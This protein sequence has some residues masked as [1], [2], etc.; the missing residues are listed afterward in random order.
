LAL[1]EFK[2]VVIGDWVAWFS[3]VE[4]AALVLGG[5]G[6]FLDHLG[7]LLNHDTLARMASILLLISVHATSSL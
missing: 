3:L 4:R 2:H 5:R 7:L 1:E 6:R